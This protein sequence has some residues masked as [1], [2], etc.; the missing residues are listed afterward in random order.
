MAAALVIH[1]PALRAAGQGTIGHDN[2]RT[3]TTE[4]L[5]YLLN[6]ERIAQGLSAV[7]GE[8]VLQRAVQWMAD[9]MAKHR[10]LSHHEQP[11]PRFGGLGCTTLAMTDLV[12]LLR[13]L[14]KDRRP[15]PQ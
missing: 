12:S 10:T 9:D 13:T 1:M 14:L 5:L 3:E 2:A 7:S 8:E 15:L 11:T 4:N 6:A